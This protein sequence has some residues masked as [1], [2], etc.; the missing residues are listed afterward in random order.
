MRLIASGVLLGRYR[1]IKNQ[2]SQIRNPLLP[3]AIGSRCGLV[4]WKSPT[5]LA[6]KSFSK[7]LAR[8]NPNRTGGY[9]SIG[10]L[11]G[12]LEKEGIRG[13]GSGAWEGKTADPRVKIP[14][15]VSP[16]L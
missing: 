8:M 4:S 14:C 3:L 7:G 10:K 1:K 13:Q 2:K 12:K 9:L 16:A 5:T 6:R 11:T 15:P